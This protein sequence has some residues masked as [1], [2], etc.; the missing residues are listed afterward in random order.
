MLTSG[1]ANILSYMLPLQV[2]ATIR[3]DFVEIVGRVLAKRPELQQELLAGYGLDQELS[4]SDMEY[5]LNFAQDIGFTAP[6]RTIV[7]N[8]KGSAFSY[9]FNEPNT[10]EGRWK[11]RSTHVHDTMFLFQNC[12]ESLSEKQKA[13]AE[14]IAGHF[15]DFFHGE[16]PF[17]AYQAGEG[18]A[19]V[20][21][22]KGEGS[23]EFVQGAALENYGRRGI[24][25]KLAEKV[26]LDVVSSIWDTYMAT[27]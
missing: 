10:W 19:M 13:S 12:N 21:G 18:G 17:P 16:E 3:D 25:P 1:K 5:V 27:R 15:L 8:F 22:L 6:V 24:V 4:E 20:Y 11:G 23:V 2:L 9:C 14:A 26:G 7:E